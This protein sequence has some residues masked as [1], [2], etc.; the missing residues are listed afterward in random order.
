MT[1]RVEQELCNSYRME[2][3]TTM[4]PVSTSQ[5]CE[6][7]MLKRNQTPNGKTMGLAGS[8]LRTTSSSQSPLSAR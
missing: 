2:T 3:K 5:L 4:A 1:P 7:W 6:L 8:T